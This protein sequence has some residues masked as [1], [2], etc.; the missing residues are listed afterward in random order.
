ML[1][2]LLEHWNYKT[3]EYFIILN[4]HFLTIIL[5]KVI[6]NGV[7]NTNAHNNLYQC[8]NFSTHNNINTHMS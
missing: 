4:A 2:I 5:P 7:C 3:I 8:I 6:L 1:G